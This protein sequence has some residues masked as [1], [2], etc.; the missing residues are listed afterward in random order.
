MR[1]RTIKTLDLYYSSVVEEIANLQATIPAM[2]A[3][4]DKAN[5]EVKLANALVFK[6]ELD[7]NRRV[8]LA[9]LAAK[10]EAHPNRPRYDQAIQDAHRYMEVGLEPRSALKQAASDAGIESGSSTMEQFI[11]YA[12]AKL[13]S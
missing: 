11:A 4:K 3:G 8:I 9:R 10:A 6:D 7:R 13:F 12:E 2:P 1:L 5:A